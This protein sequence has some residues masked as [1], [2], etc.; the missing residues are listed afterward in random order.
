MELLT[1]QY[2]YLSAGNTHHTFDKMQQQYSD[3]SPVISFEALDL[4]LPSRH[5]TKKHGFAMAG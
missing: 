2:F 4:A 5:M 3:Y 1:N